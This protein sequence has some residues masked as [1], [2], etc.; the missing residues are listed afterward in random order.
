MTR[1]GS[2]EML[3]TANL[4]V[5]CFGIR[6]AL[7]VAKRAASSEAKRRRLQDEASARGLGGP[8]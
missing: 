7:R 6:S 4:T 5:V 2:C 1:H 8:C 3:D